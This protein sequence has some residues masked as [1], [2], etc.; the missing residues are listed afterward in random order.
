MHL[1]ITHQRPSLPGKVTLAPAPRTVPSPAPSGSGTPLWHSSLSPTQPHRY[2]PTSC[3]NWCPW[4]IFSE[5]GV[6]LGAL[7][8]TQKP[9]QLPDFL[10]SCPLSSLLQSP[11]RHQSW[12][13]RIHSRADPVAAFPASGKPQF[14]DLPG[15]GCSCPTQTHFLPL[16]WCGAGEQLQPCPWMG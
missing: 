6:R 12:A 2:F 10:S 1:P 9:L 15:V 8:P 11:E 16:C 4:H 5:A 3:T 7:Q 13:V 14:V